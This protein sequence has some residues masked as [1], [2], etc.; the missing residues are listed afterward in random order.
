M[1]FNSCETVE[2]VV[3]SWTGVWCL[4]EKH[5]PYFQSYDKSLVGSE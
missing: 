4:K 2:D 1:L 5:F 3:L